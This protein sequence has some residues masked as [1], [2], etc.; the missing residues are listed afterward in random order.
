MITRAVLLAAG[1]GSRLGALTDSMPKPLLPVAGRPIIVHILD[2]LRR[3]GIEEIAIVTGYLGDLLERELGNGEASDLR[4][5]YL[6]QERLE[7][8]ARALALARDWLGDERFFVGWGDILVRPENYRRV[9][10]ASHVA[11][12]A[13]AVNEVDDPCAG[14][15]VYLD[16]ANVVQRIVEKPVR[17]TS[18]T[19]WNNAGLCV[20]GPS[21]W[22]Q[23]D[24]LEPSAR[25]EY[26][27]PQALAALVATG[28][29]V[30][31]APVEG[32]WFDIGTPEDLERARTA[33]SR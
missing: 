32:E 16:D 9:I 12:A 5:H 26:E 6:R 24:R 15:A 19:H 30:V 4:L 20:V 33:Y 22:E 14:A 17:G 8:S 10:R 13:I 18:S 27:L 1:R 31:A 7:G 21:V 23:I 3:A 25:G 29:R 28:A 11:D 2:G